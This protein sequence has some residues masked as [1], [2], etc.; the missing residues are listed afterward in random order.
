LQDGV[1]YLL[2]ETAFS[3]LVGGWYFAILPQ[4]G[5]GEGGM[6]NSKFKV[7]NSKFEVRG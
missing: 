7:Q 5:C 6:Q 1:P 4:S 3:F 2:A